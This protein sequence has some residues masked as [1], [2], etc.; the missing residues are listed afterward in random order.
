MKTT[1]KKNVFKRPTQQAEP[2]AL[3]YATAD[4]VFSLDEETIKALPKEERVALLKACVDL[5]R[6]S[7]ADGDY[8]DAQKLRTIVDT[9]CQYTLV[10]GGA[11]DLRRQDWENNHSSILGSIH[12]YVLNNYSFPTVNTI[13]KDTKLSRQ[14]VHAHLK[15]GIANKFY[16]ERLKTWEYLT[17]AILKNLY[18]ESING[19]VAASKVLLDNIYRLGQPPAQHIRQQNNYLQINNTKVDEVVIAELP[20]D[21]RRQ[22]V[23]IITQYTQKTA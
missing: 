12:N 6:T 19:N 20:D 4:D 10:Q 9:I 16:Q 1:V 22:I 14:T 15:E 8:Q 3:K 17:D 11:E 13:A 18:K 21:A 23:D 2:P 7:E 5:I